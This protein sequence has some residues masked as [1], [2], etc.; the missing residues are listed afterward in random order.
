MKITDPEYVLKLWAASVRPSV[1][2]VRPTGY[3]K[4]SQGDNRMA[5][6]KVIVETCQAFRTSKPVLWTW[7]VVEAHPTE[8]DAK[9]VAAFKS[10]LGERLLTEPIIVDDYVVPDSDF[11]VSVWEAYDRLVDAWTPV[12]RKTLQRWVS[13]NK[14]ANYKMGRTRLV[15][16]S[17][18]KKLAPTK[19]LTEDQM[20]EFLE[21]NKDCETFVY[22]EA[23]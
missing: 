14:V 8:R 7:Y 17:E 12:T 5:I 21:K 22:L 1:K 4:P 3:E 10:E 15:K 2:L 16:W 18:V 13:A 6:A 11:Y 19:R 23:S 20:A 9:I